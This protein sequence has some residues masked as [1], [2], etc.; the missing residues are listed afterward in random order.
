LYVGEQVQAV[1]LALLGKA[2]RRVQEPWPGGSFASNAFSEALVSRRVFRLFPFALRSQVLREVKNRQNN[3]FGLQQGLSHAGFFFSGGVP[4]Y[5]SVRSM[6]PSFRL[7]RLCRYPG[8]AGELC[9]SEIKRLKTHNCRI[10][11]NIDYHVTRFGDHPSSI[12][13]RAFHAHGF[14][15]SEQGARYF[16]R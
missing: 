9:I 13:A 12:L 11:R 3:F 15:G 1:Q 5:V 7:C 14:I 4:L 8:A 6:S 10:S 16:V 2:A